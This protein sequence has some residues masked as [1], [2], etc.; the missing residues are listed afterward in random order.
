MSFY[1]YTQLINVNDWK[2]DEDKEVANL[3][4]LSPSADKL[5]FL[6]KINYN[7]SNGEQTNYQ[8]NYQV[9]Y[10]ADKKAAAGGAF[11]SYIGAAW[12][13][14]QGYD[15]TIW[16]VRSKNGEYYLVKLANTNS[17]IPQISVDYYS[18]SYGE[19]NNLP[20]FD[21]EH[22]NP[23]GFILQ[24]SPNWKIDGELIG[25]T[26][27]L[28]GP[29]STYY[30]RTNDEITFLNKDIF[31]FSKSKSSKEYKDKETDDT[32]IFDTKTFSFNFTQLNDTLGLLYNIIYGTDAKREQ[33]INDTNYFEKGQPGLLSFLTSN[34]NEVSYETITLT[35]NANGYS[36]NSTTKI[37]NW[38]FN[39]TNINSNNAISV[40]LLI[41]ETDDLNTNQAVYCNFEITKWE[42][43]TLVI[44]G[45]SA[46]TQD[47]KLVLKYTH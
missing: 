32:Q 10:Q 21:K 9:N 26:S 42:G 16:Q 47:V 34:N 7:L 43:N 13:E 41:D 29:T 20:R 19:E 28:K 40:E 25:S 45:T 12:E 3:I 6:Y 30:Q 17:V 2:I 14:N 24:A 11:A 33:L 23:A 35:A 4:S 46:P 37:Y 22:S 39:N 27:Q 38:T 15:G 44:S 1:G 8:T 36:F 5:N 18:P 31:K